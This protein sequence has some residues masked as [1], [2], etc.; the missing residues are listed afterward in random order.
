MSQTIAFVTGATGH[1]GGA[2]ARELL[3]AGV[4]VHALVRNPSSKSAIELQRL[5]AQLFVGDFDDLSSLE[6]AIRGATAVFLNVSPVFSDTQ[7]EVVHAKNIIDTAVISGTVTSVVYSS[8]TMTGKHEGFPNWGPEHPMAWYWLNKDKIESMVRGSGIKYWTILRP[9]FLMNNYHLPMASFMFP[10]LVQKR[11]F[12]T[13][14]KPDSVMTVIDPTDVGKFAAAAITEPL[15]FNTH[16]I[17]LGVESLTPAQIVQ[18]LRRVSGEDI[19]LQ[20]YSEQ[21]A[22]DLALRN[23]VINAQFWTN[24]VGYQV[25]FKELEKYPIRLTKFSNYLKR[26]RSE[27]LQTFTHPRNPSL[28]IT[29]TPVY[30]NS[31]IK[32]FDLRLV[33]G[34]PNLI[35][36]QTLVEIADPE[37]LHPIR[38]YPANAGQASDSKGDVV[39]TYSA[40][41]FN[42]D[43]EP[44]VALLDLRRDQD[45]INGAG[46]CLFI[47]PPDDKTYSISLAWDLSQAP[48]GTRAIWTHGEGPG[49]VKKLGSTKVLSESHFAVGPSLHSY[50]PTA[51]ASG[52]FGFYWF[53]EPNFEVLRLAR[54]AQTLFQ[55]MKSF[56]HDS[57]SAYSIFLRASAS[58]RGIGGAAL[59]RSF[60]LNY[61]LGNGNTWK[62][63]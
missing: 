11:I 29:V 52:G 47:L 6:T 35:A 18:E 54:W 17:D 51:S 22:K 15:S 63:F 42:N 41:H 30:E 40:T 39:V 27:V 31:I 10:D 23:P 58:S 2:T 9:A 13:A 46:M 16:E 44:I 12:L 1:Q 50:P 4:K 24:E 36:G 34:N 32:S 21:E 55:Y 62:S 5:G 14:Y 37:E 48:D 26:H 43:S 8:V 53:G 25:D 60:M 33:I 3:N 56:F 28:D 57:E 20:F 38:P 49:A 45:G 7:Q 59:L 19:G 61:E